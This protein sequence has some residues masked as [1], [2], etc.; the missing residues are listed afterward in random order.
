[1][2]KKPTKDRSITKKKATSH[3]AAS[4]DL[5]PSRTEA[6]GVKGG[7][8]AKLLDKASPKLAQP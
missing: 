3:K 1:M 4:V 7:Y 6:Q 5:A 8:V 2:E